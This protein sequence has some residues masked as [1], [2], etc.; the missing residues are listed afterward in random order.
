MCSGAVKEGYGGANLK[1]CRALNDARRTV[2]NFT[3]FEWYLTIDKRG[4]IC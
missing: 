3:L 4:N 1:F 2:D